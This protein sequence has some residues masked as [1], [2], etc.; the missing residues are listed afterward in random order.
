MYNVRAKHI[1]CRYIANYIL[2]DI[3]KVFGNGHFSFGF[4]TV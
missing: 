3:L 1:K 4:E 2:I